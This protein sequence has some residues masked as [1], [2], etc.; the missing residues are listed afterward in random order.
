MERQITKRRRNLCLMAF[1]LL[2]ALIFFVVFKAGVYRGF[3]DPD[4]SLPYLY[5][6]RMALGDAPY[7]DFAVEYP[8][9]ALL[10]MLVPR[11]FTPFASPYLWG[12]TLEIL[13]FDFLALL[14]V[15]SFSERLK[16]SLWQ[17]LAVYTLLLLAIGP[18]IINRYDLI[19]AVMAL[20]AV[21]FFARGNARFAWALLAL[22]A[23][24]KLFPALLAPL[25]FIY[26]CGRGQARRAW[27]GAA[28]FVVAAAV[29]ALPFIILSPGGFA[30]SF[31]YHAD[32]GL[33]IE[34]L[35]AS[36]L[37]LGEKLGLTS[38]A[39]ERSAGSTNV[40]SPLADTLATISP[41]LVL[42]ALALV[43]WLYFRRER[44]SFLNGK[45]RDDSSASL[46]SF[47]LLAILAFMLLGKV[48]SP[49]FI[50]WLLPFMPLLT[51]PHRRLSWLLF[52]VIGLLSYLI[53]PTGYQTLEERNV[54]MIAL[55]VARNAALVGLAAA[56][57]RSVVRGSGEIKSA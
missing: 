5:A 17:A 15:A 27:Q 56:V 31:T 22:G 21:Y 32:R 8:P 55:L 9:L 49:Q 11:L 16:L 36:L 47:S 6:S 20:A 38:L 2:H 3:A 54:R 45:S 40:V 18:I 14:L 52:I 19:P 12:F 44:G 1:A 33:Q 30:A 41:L 50:I 26:D 48:L 43:Y 53:Y 57:A 39:I 34:S 25:F 13:L 35:P 7:R 29:I 28:V 4:M 46:I 23:M 24:T 51:G 37:L 42:V 10:F